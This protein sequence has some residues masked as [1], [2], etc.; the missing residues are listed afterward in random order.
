MSTPRFLKDPAFKL[1]RVGEVAAFHKNVEERDV[2]DFSG[3]DLRGTDFRKVDLDKII[4]R[5]AYL[6]DADFRGC[7]LRHLDLEGASLHDARIA[8]TYFPD[9]VTASEIRMTLRHGTRIRTTQTAQA[10]KPAGKE[11]QPSCPRKTDIE[12]R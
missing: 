2:V 7:D 10:S 11:G 6:R 8:G 5:D 3:A 9:N 4:L 12:K 1:L